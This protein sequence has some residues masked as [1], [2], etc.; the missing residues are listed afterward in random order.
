MSQNN[1][2]SL[3]VHDL[4]LCMMGHS[5]FQYLYAGLELGVFNLLYKK[6]KLSREE[7]ARDLNLEEI[8]NRCLLFGLSALKFI[9]HKNET[10]TNSELINEIIKNDKIDLLIKVS[11][12]QAYIVYLG[13]ID[14]LES[15]KTNQNVGLRR[16]A[17]VENELY[18]RIASDPLLHKVFFDYMSAWS[19][20]SLPLLLE[21]VDFSESR[22][23]ADV[24]GGDATISIALAQTYSQLSVKLLDIEAGKIPA[25]EKINRNNLN[26]RIQ[27][28]LCNVFTDEF[29]KDCDC[30]LYAHF[31]VIWSPEE[32]IRL[33][34]KTYD[35]LPKGG[36][37][38][39][40][41][42]MASDNEDGP[43]FAALDSAYFMAIPS[44]GGL[45]YSMKDYEKWLK[46]AGFNEIS[47]VFCESW[48]SPH[49]A[50][51]AF[52]S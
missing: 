27:P 19:K 43:L 14:F 48:W 4:T 38:V 25:Q 47:R 16:F 24:G 22:M 32:N 15:I 11:R 41:N 49:G 28:L 18:S 37:V 34:K 44:Q 5:A 21:S 12:F 23:I 52:K 51:V 6:T 2:I 42:S 33:L 8:P 10:Y 50:I 9:Q 1:N 13:Q 7:I 26:D 36:K 20:E 30:F 39:I 40:F 46:T 29:P 3:S 17:G 45:I 35:A 31:L